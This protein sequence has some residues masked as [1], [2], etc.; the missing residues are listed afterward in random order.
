MVR[1]PLEMCLLVH[2]TILRLLRTNARKKKNVTFEADACVFR[3]DKGN[4]P[5]GDYSEQVTPPSDFKVFPFV[6]R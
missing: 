5:V 2:K 4:W 1:P 3:L 6:D